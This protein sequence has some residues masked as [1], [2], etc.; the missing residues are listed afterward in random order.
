M[1]PARGARGHQVP[2]AAVLRDELLCAEQHRAIDRGGVG[3]RRGE[4]R[5]ARQVVRTRVVQGKC[6]SISVDLGGRR[7]MKQQ[8]YLRPLY[9][10]S[11]Q[12]TLRSYPL[13]MYYIE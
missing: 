7:I 6:V 10:R 12:T 4:P 11:N 8:T 2:Q 3:N 9:H 13:I 5:G 1:R